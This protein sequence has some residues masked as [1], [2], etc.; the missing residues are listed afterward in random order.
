L[1]LIENMDHFDFTSDALVAGPD[2][3]VGYWPPSTPARTASS[4][5]IARYVHRFFAAALSQDADSRA[6]LAQ[7]PEDSIPG[8]KVTIEHR[9]ATPGS[10]TY[11]Q[12][13]EAVVAG[14]AAE[15]IRE[16]RAVAAAEPGHFM[17]QQ[18][19]LDRA[20]ASLLFTWGLARETIPVI[21]FMG[22]RYPSPRAPHGYLAEAY[23]LA[24]DT[25]A[26]IDALTRLGQ[27]YPDAAA[28]VQRRIDALRA[29]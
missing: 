10:I 27:Q 19:N 3:A 2:F 17:L 12:F 5:T 14:R 7:V 29:R 18:N 8:R 11:E 28:G 25:A 26:A 21:E 1:L 9:A 23:L 24:G 6:F 16:L 20:I 15:A 13:I 4:R 22:E